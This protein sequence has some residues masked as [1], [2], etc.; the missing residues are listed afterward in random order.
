MSYD[1]IFMLH[2]GESLVFESTFIICTRMKADFCKGNITKYNMMNRITNKDVRTLS[3]IHDKSNIGMLYSYTPR[4][5]VLLPIPTYGPI[6][7]K[8]Y[9]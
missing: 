2:I 5:P 3:Y 4:T 8:H 1:R 6:P 7:V 9:L